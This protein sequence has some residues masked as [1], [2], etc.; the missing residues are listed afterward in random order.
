MKEDVSSS[1]PRQVLMGPTVRTTLMTALGISVLMEEPVWMESTP[2]TANALQ[3]GLVR[4]LSVQ[5]CL[6]LS[7]S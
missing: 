2:T 1:H 4:A 6:C 5:S 3:S 7:L